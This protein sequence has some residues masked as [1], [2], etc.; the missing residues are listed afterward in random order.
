MRKMN[1]YRQGIVSECLS[2]VPLSIHTL[3]L[4]HNLKINLKEFLQ[5]QKL[6]SK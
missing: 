5:E 6:H 4:Y 1:M 3:F 2:V